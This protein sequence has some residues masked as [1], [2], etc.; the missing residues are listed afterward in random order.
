MTDNVMGTKKEK[1]RESGGY[2]LFCHHAALARNQLEK[3][4]TV[5]RTTARA[6]IYQ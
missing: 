1:P 6:A 4:L 3:P 5:F 2:F